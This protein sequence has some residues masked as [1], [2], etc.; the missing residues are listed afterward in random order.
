MGVR[1]LD[2]TDVVDNFAQR[3][4]W[5]RKVRTKFCGRL[6]EQWPELLQIILKHQIQRCTDHGLVWTKFQVHDLPKSVNHIYL[7]NKPY[8]DKLTG[9]KVVKYR[10]DPAVESF[11]LLVMEAMGE[12]RW[13]WKP[14]GVTSA[15]VILE[16]PTWITAKREVRE[17]DVDNKLKVPL[18][19]IQ[20]ATEIP[21][22]LHWHLHVFKVASKWSRTTVYLFDEGDVVE[23]YL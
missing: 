4:K 12:D 10:L 14:T 3:S 5:K 19:A 6:G 7:K 15:V 1:S 8:K 20:N 18:D 17:M 22:E 21:D 13:K 23:Y 11:R 16:S 9:A 2:T